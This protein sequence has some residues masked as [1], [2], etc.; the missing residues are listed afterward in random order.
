[1]FEIFEAVL[2]AYVKAFRNYKPNAE[3]ADSLIKKVMATSFNDIGMQLLL[4]HD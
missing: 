2:L 4:L 1:M 3:T